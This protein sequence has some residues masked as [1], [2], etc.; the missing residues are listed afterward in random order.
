VKLRFRPWQL[1]AAVVLLCL[2]VVGLLEWN[3]RR[4]DTSNAALYRLLPARDATQLFIDVQSL[5]RAGLLEMLAGSKA[6]EELDYQRF[7]AEIGFDYREDLDAVLA[8][9]WGGRSVFLLRGRF[10]WERIRRWAERGGAKCVNGYCG[11]ETSRPG[12]AVSFYML[13]PNVMVVGIAPDTGGAYAVSTKRTIT[14]E[15][16]L[17]PQPVWFRIPA[18]VLNDAGQLPTGTRAFASAVK[19][20]ERVTLGVGPAGQGFEAELRAVFR[21]EAEAVRMRDQLREATDTLRKFFARDRQTPNPNDL[22]GVL[23]AGQF[24]QE[25]NQLVG[26]WPIR[27]E[28]LQALSQGKL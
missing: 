25:G 27:W 6:A 23:V 1:S 4:N 15:P 2:A 20:A 5:R 19:G 26:R 13:Y 14:A 28:F 17:P 12:R 11:M 21:D 9:F 8:S 16:N 10:D 7:V 24:E 22:S 18:A 3:R